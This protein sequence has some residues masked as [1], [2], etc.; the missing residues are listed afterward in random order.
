MLK[1]LHHEESR[2]KDRGAFQ[3]DAFWEGEAHAIA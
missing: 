1:L 3:R 2:G